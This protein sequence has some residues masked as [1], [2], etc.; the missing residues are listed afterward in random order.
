MSGKTARHKIEYPVPSDKV[1]DVA[2]INQRA[3]NTIDTLLTAASDR[4]QTGSLAL[5]QLYPGEQTNTY[6]VTFTKPFAAQPVVIAQSENQRHNVA[7]WNVSSTGFSW[8]VLNNTNGTSA[9]ASVMWVAIG[10]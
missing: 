8:M 3:A 2:A 10:A 6:T 7:I 1:V 4:I 9:A 5:N